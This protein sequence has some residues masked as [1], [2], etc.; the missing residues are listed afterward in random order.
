MHRLS[1]YRI[2]H[3]LY[4]VKYFFVGIGILEPLIALAQ[5]GCAFPPQSD[6]RSRV[7]GKARDIRRRRKSNE[8]MHLK[9]YK[10][11]I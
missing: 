8:R 10:F 7:G 11:M 9:T 4:N 1:M 6:D 2:A 5:L 3:L